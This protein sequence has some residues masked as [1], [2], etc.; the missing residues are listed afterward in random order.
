MKEKDNIYFYSNLLEGKETRGLWGKDRRFAPEK[1]AVNPSVLAYFLPIIQPWITEESKVLDFGCGPGSFFSVLSP[2]CQELYGID[3]V[4]AFIDAANAHSINAGLKNA[5]A[6]T[7]E[8]LVNRVD[9]EYFDVVLM[10]DVIHHVE[11]VNEVM[12]RA[13]RMLK[14]N[15]HL[16]VFEPNRRNPLLALM[17]LLD[18]NERTL[19]KM[20]NYPYYRKILGESGFTVVDHDWNAMLIGPDSSIARTIAD[21]LENSPVKILRGFLPKMTITARRGEVE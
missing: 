8:E 11:N 16:I 20:G 7:Y 14:P 1:I 10:L 17:C 19:L 18:K 13:K 9:H 3:V 6:H 2:L 21:K 12:N 15:G 4:P 5:S